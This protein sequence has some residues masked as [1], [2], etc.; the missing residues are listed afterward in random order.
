MLTCWMGKLF[1]RSCICFQISRLQLTAALFARNQF[2]MYIT[3][4]CL[5]FA[6]VA[7]GSVVNALQPKFGR[8]PSTAR[9]SVC[10]LGL[11]SKSRAASDVLF[12]CEAV[13][14]TNTSFVMYINDLY[15]SY[16]EFF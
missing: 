15:T 11:T 3:L 10:F 4:L 14:L 1:T 2:V 16:L 12:L 7:Q 9:E 13:S 5:Y 6:T 8:H